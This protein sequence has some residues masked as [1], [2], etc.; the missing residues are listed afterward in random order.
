MRKRIKLLAIVAFPA[1]AHGRGVTPYLPLNLDPQVERQIERVLILGQKPALRRPIAAAQVLEAL[2][3]ACE[4]DAALCARVRRYLR[5]Y[6]GDTGVEF[7]SVEVSIGTGSSSIIPNAHGQAEQSHYQVAAAG[8]LQF[9]DHVLLNLGGVATQGLTPAATPTGSILSLGFDVAQLDVGYRDHW[10]SPMVNSS[11][12]ISTEAPTMPS[13]TL[14]NY[15]PLTG[16]GIEYEL[17]V[18]R[19]SYSTKIQTVPDGVQTQGYPQMSG[20]HVGVEPVSGWALGANRVLVYGGGAAGGQSVG[21]ILNAFFNPS[22]AQS[23]GFGSGQPVVGK[24]EASV[25]T[26]L[27]FPGR[28]PF[29]GYVEYSANDTSTGSNFLFGKPDLS[30]GIHV[31][32]LGAFDITLESSVWEPTWYVHGFSAVQT[33]YGDGISNEHITI[34]NWFG[35]QRVFGDAVGGQ[36]Q[37]VRV[38]WEPHFGGR[39]EAQLRILRNDSFYSPVAY[40]REYLGSLSYAYPW[41]GYAVGG[42][43]DAGQDVFGDRFARLSAF[44]RLGEALADGGSGEEPEPAPDGSAS[45]T[46][47]FVDAGANASKVRQDIV[48]TSPATHTPVEYGPHLGLGARRQVSAHQDL[49]MRLEAEEVHGKLLLGVRAL[50]YRWRFDNPLAVGAFLGAARYSAG[51]PAMGW[52]MGL[53]PEWRGIVPGWDLSA[54]AR[55]GMKLARLRVLPTDP[56]QDA[57][58]LDSFYD[59]YGVALSLSHRL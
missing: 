38:G 51:T 44:L 4:V 50:D 41:H 36:T 25:V 14:S 8:Y 48:V 21:T 29:T 20:V 23:S 13:L 45:P 46:S 30:F 5:R 17:F 42:Q 32:R 10:W 16:L 3:K 11:M 22:R 37:L 57:N 47:V 19:M 39:L 31:P 27:I 18:A 59:V 54:T 53:G 15:R 24:Q 33:G 58:R 34:G 9:T 40:R 2:P 12:L 43:V 55:Y 52:Y 56:Q 6:M 26:Q 1:L 35:D 7:A 49:G 28:V